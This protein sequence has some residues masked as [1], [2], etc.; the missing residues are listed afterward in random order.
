MNDNEIVYVA[1]VRLRLWSG[2]KLAT[3]EPGGKFSFDGDEGIDVAM[4]LRN[5]SI[6]RTLA[7]VAVKKEKKHGTNTR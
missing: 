1:N 7:T 6:S 4:L 5:K 2:G 3:I